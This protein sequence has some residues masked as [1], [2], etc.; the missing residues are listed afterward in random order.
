MGRTSSAGDNLDLPLGKMTEAAQRVIDRAVE[1]SRRRE[2]SLLASE[3][4]L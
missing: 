1:E 4:V 2:Y 3:H